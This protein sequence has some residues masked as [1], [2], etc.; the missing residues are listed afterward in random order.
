MPTYE[1]FLKERAGRDEALIVMTAEN[2]AVI[3]NLPAA[4]GPR[5]IDVGICEQTMIGAAAGLALRGRTPVAHALA[6]FLTM[7][8]FEFIRTDVGIPGLPV[9]LVGGVPGFLS[10]ANG[11]THQA[12][13]DVALMRGIPGMNVF[14][15]ADREELL[16]GMQAVLDARKPTYVRYFGGEPAVAHR[17]PFVIGKAETVAE[18]RDVAILVYGF[19]L[20]EAEHARQA[21]EARG[22][23]VRLVNMRMPKPADE[24]AIVRAARE[25]KLVVTV[26]DHFLTGGLYTIVAEVLLRHRRSARVLPIALEDRWFKPA[27][28]ADVLSY[29][30]F[31]GAALA[32]RIEK[33]Y[34]E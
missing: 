11:P 3:R 16:A 18:G 17:E 31:N 7:R 12:I 29:E 24:D 10:E 21:L 27:L 5:F 9:T 26:E 13:E 1:E 2:R 33:A 14:C 30:G 20:G 19:L 25:T 34:R 15:P 28:L 4:L 22:I 8:A 6:T 23:S 32:E